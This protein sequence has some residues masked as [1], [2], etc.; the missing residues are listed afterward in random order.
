MIKDVTMDN[1]EDNKSMPRPPN[2]IKF[3]MN[4][5]VKWCQNQKKAK[6]CTVPTYEEEI[7]VC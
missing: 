3:Q 6:E 7:Y 4:Q 5:W 2:F 1:V